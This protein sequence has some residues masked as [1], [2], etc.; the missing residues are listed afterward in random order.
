M[1]YGAWAEQ[2]LLVPGT[3]NSGAYSMRHATTSTALLGL[4]LCL[5]LPTPAQAH[6]SLEK[7][8]THLSRYGDGQA[9]IK[10]APCGHA[11][12]PRGELV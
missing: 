5:G 4:A 3:K 9:D 1:P 8:G 12:G 11:N 6:I 7:G 2:L 10:E